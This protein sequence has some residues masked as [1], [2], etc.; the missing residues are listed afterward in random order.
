MKCPECLEHITVKISISEY[1]NYIATASCEVHQGVKM[2]QVILTPPNFVLPA[3][4]TYNGKVK[5]TGG[6]NRSTARVPINII[7]H[8][9]DGSTKVT[10]IG[11]KKDIEN[12]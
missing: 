4:V 8:M 12:E 11:D 2:T 6:N 9:P 10:R 7:D 1:D 3:S 5:V